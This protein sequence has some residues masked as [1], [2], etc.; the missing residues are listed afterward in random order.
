MAC[1][2][3]ALPPGESHNTE[4]DV[5]SVLLDFLQRIAV[6]ACAVFAI[7]LAI[8]VVLPRRSRIEDSRRTAN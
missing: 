2:Y 1:R 7:L 4:M 6:G 5:V 8:W 3:L